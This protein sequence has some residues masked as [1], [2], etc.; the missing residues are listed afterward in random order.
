VKSLYLLNLQFTFSLVAFALIARWHIAPRLRRLEIRDA[1]VALLWIHAFRY[2]PLTLLAPG[3][4]DPTVPSSV[5]KTIAYGDF[6]SAVLA[7]VALLLLRYKVAGAFAVTWLFN[8]VG[9]VDIFVAL[10]QGV[11]VQ[12]FS[13]SIGFNWYILNFYVPVLCVTHVMITQ[14][15][16]SMRKKAAS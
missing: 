2:A 14:R 8:I 9:I 3:Q 11:R 13:Y 10:L 16:L 12:L 1:L 7:L 4:I 15:L 5:T 6:L